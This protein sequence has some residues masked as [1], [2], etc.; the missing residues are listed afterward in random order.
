MENSIII[1]NLENKGGFYSLFFFLLNHY[2]YCSKNNINFKIKSDKWLFKYRYGWE[3]YFKPCNLIFNDLNYNEL[4]YSHLNIIENYSIYEYKN[5]IPNIYNYNS[6]TQIKINN[7]YQRFNLIKNNYDSIFIRRGDKLGKES[8]L[9]PEENYIKLLLN[10]NPSCKIIYLQTD[11]YNCYIK[12]KEYIKNNNLNINI[13][14]LCNE[15][16]VGFVVYNNQRDILNNAVL[17]NEHNKEYLSTIINKLNSSKSVEDM[18]S[19]EIYKH[20]M[21]M[22]MGVDIILNSNVCITDYQSNVSRFIK[23]AHNNSNNVFDVNNPNQDIDYNKIIC[24]AYS[25]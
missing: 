10:K 9:I 22:L 21:D 19:D 17:N 7:I 1:S 2:I 25:F 5:Y 16:N 8:I 18:N 13:Y 11:D 15:N 20:T 14:T 12:L 3:D 23:L 4:I 6:L 24:P